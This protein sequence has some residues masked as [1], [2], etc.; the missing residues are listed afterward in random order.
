MP[1]QYPKISCLTVTKNRLVALKSAIRCFCDQTYPE[2]EMIIVSDGGSW[3]NGA[4]QRYLDELDRNDIRFVIVNETCTLGKLRNISMAEATGGILC[5]W[6]DDDLYHPE[7]LSIQYAKMK[8]KNAKACC[9]TDQLQYFYEE[10]E[11]YWCHWKK[12]ESQPLYQ[13]IP[14]TIMLYKDKRFRYPEAGEHA[15]SGE[16][17][18]FLLSIF[19]T[20]PIAELEGMGHLYIYTY[21]GNN[22]FSEAH[23]RKAVEKYALPQQEV[24]QGEAGICEALDYHLLPSP[25]R[26][27]DN[28][29]QIVFTWMYN[30]QMEL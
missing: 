11:L 21:S 29:Q 30:Y 6:D 24:W 23:H 27:L 1:P 17:S 7:R 26:V 22:T 14:G 15:S 18:A 8:E 9:M 4:V 10:R 16:D 13:L 2:K 12:N 25:V 5:Q 28:R 3:Y 19:E 20:F